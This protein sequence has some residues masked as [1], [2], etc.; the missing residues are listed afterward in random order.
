MIIFHHIPKTAGTTINDGVYSKNPNT[1]LIVGKEGSSA[2]ERI[3]IHDYKFIGGH[4]PFHEVKPL[5]HSSAKHISILRD[6]LLRIISYFEM[7]YRDNTVFREEICSLDKW[8]FGFDIFYDR[9]IRKANLENISCSYFTKSRN[10]YDAVSTIR[11]NFSILGDVTRMEDFELNFDKIAEMEEGFLKP[12]S[13][14]KKNKSSKG[15]SVVDKISPVTLSRIREDNSED[16]K[17]RYWLIERHN[18]LYLNI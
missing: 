3:N 8:G 16:F 5:L 4:L 9:F 11:D 15:E 10:F 1:S 2:L 7:A 13:Y 6:P 17:L 12:A 14:P 18:G